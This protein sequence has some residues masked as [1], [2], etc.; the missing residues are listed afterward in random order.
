MKEEI[1][2]EKVEHL[3]LELD[4]DVGKL[5]EAF[6]KTSFQSRNIARCYDVY[7]AM[8]NDPS[9]VTIFLGLAGAMV[10][11]GMRK[12]IRDMVEYGMVDVLVSTGANLYHDI[13][14][15]YGVHHY[16]GSPNVDDA[17]LRRIR[18]D[19]VY[20]TF[21]DDEGLERVDN[22][23][24]QIVDEMEVGVYSSR[25]FLALL[26]GRL[27]DDSSILAT[28]VRRGVPVFCPA[29]SDSS[30]GIALVKH[31]LRCE[32]R[33]RKPVVIDTVKDCYEIMQ[34]RLKSRKSGAVYIGGGVP[35]NFIQQI[36]VTLDILGYKNPGFAHDFAIQITMDDPKWGGLSGATIEEAQSWGKVKADATKATVYV[37]ATIGLPLIVGAL[38]KTQ[39]AALKR[40][41]RLL[42]NWDK[43][44]L[45]DLRVEKDVSA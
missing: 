29:I 44:K 13:C 6:H 31:Y 16:L 24:A 43:G 19:R 42:F 14:E 1:L 27:N 11:A 18:V 35:K 23:I 34:I 32:E 37:D 41:G 7:A 30:I 15:A 12:V 3:N 9:R 39:R 26:G 40:R 17:F 28:A 45:I 33:G 36:P 10:P 21:T 2:R 5:V 20:D 22:I 8:L 25:E 38:M 4:E